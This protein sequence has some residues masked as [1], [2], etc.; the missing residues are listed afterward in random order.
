MTGALLQ[1]NAVSKYFPGVKALEEVSITLEAGS[2]HAL[3]GENG[4]G[5]STLIKIVTGVYRADEGE[6]LLDGRP[7]EFGGPRDAIAHRIGVVH[8]ERNL[9]PRFSIGENIFLEQLG[10]YPFRPIDYRSINAQASQWLR[11]LD[12][13]VDPA[14]PVAELSVA[15]M[16]LVE[17]AKALA[18]TPNG[19][20]IVSVANICHSV[21]KTRLG[22]VKN[23]LVPC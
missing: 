19:A 3:L 15:R 16:Q 18:L 2:I 8:Q 14:T 4:A 21:A 6:L 5:K 1:A 9:I 23:N 17:I 7:V 20:Q 11:M 10:A 22:T 13:D 12:L